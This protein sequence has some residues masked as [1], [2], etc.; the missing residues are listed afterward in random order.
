MSGVPPDNESCRLE[1]TDSRLNQPSKKME[2]IIFQEKYT[3]RSYETDAFSKVS[4]TALCNFFQD[5]AGK[6]ASKL[7]FG[8]E[9][10]ISK[11][12]F[13]VLSRLKVAIFKYPG[14]REEIFIKTWP[15]GTKGLLAYRDFQIL[16]K[17]S[18]IL[19]L[20]KSGWLAISHTTRRPQKVDF[21]TELLPALPDIFALKDPLDKL[22]QVEN[23]EIGDIFHVRFSD[24]D[25]NKHVNNVK[26]IQWILD[27][28]PIE[29]K[30]RLWLNSFEI[31]F[32]VES[33]INNEIEVHIQRNQKEE[34]SYLH[35]LIR[36][37]DNKEICRAR[38]I[39]RNNNYHSQFEKE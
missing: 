21:T 39:W 12:L 13:W 20:A 33:T 27:S 31:N 34:L 1:T 8:F 29:M 7:N 3:I 32:L 15:S 37:D 2:E 22:P 4:L 9:Y 28:Y 30:E 26:Y 16:D 18:N 24:L 11:K 5:I 23:S 6:H 36:K 14:W 17:H 35:S 25:M 10:M 38:A 19:G